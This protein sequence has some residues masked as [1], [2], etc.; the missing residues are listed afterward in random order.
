[1]LGPTRDTLHFLIVD[2]DE[3]D[4]EFVEHALRRIGSSAK[5]SSVDNGFDALRFLRRESPFEHVDAVD[6]VLLD[7]SMPRMSGHEVLARIRGDAKLAALPVVM[8]TSSASDR[9]VD[10]A[11]ESE[12][13]SYV[14]KPIDVGEFRAAIESIHS[15]WS[16]HC[17][18]P[19]AS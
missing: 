15:Y 7:I 10:R 4:I 6:V 16:Q 3:S 9:D 2:D 17:S 8:F 18:L 1:M 13:S 5:V 14:V 19:P 12:A 11:Y